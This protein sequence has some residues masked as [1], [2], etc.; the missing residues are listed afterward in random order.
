[1]PDDR[2]KHKLMN[3]VKENGMIPVLQ[4]LQGML[5]NSTTDYERQLKADLQE[6]IRN[7]KKAT[8]EDKPRSD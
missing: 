7:Y 2:L 4:K 6:A 3:I 1:M 8:H 5:Q